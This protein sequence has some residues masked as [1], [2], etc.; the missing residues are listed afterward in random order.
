MKKVKLSEESYSKL[1]NKLVNEISYGTVDNAY[2]KSS[3]IFG[4]VESSFDTFFE[5]L[6][7]ALKDSK[8]NPY[9][10]KINKFAKEIDAI[11]RRKNAQRNEFFKA[12][13][14]DVNPNNFYQSDD[15]ENNDIGDMDLNYLR[16]KYPR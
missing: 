8:G 14:L 5:A 16:S 3:K 12:T 11:L 7:D 10:S 4:Y 6:K 15:A 2:D 13:T 9:L 1:K